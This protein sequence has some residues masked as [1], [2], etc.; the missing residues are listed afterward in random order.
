M[1]ES[2]SQD[3]PENFLPF[4][5]GTVISLCA[6]E[7]P[8]GERELF[9]EFA[10]LLSALVH[11]GYHVRGSAVL[12]AYQV[13]DPAEDVRVLGVATTDDRAAARAT[14]ERELIAL[15]EAADFTR[16]AADEIE[17][18]FSE[19]ALMKVRL[20]VDDTD[21]EKVLFFRRGIAQRSETVRSLFGLRRRRIEFTSYSMVLVYVAFAESS[22]EPTASTVMVKL[23]QNV[24]RNDL[25]ML[26]PSVRV[27]MRPVDKL[28][29]GVPAVVS[30]IIV[31][32]TK[33]VGSLGL[34][35]LLAAF[36]LGLREESV[37]LDRTAL[38]TLG[39][40]AAAFG[41]YVVR[42][43]TKFKNRRIELM[44]TLS[45]HLYFRNLDN[46]S[47]V[48]GRLLAAAEDSEVKETVLAYHFL[49]TA[50]TPLT[51]LELDRRVENWFRDRW[52]TSFDF[53]V[54]DGLRTLRALGLLIEDADGT[55]RVLELGE[56]R[57]RVDRHWDDQFSVRVSVS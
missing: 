5:P 20:E 4:R 44:K 42:Q 6:R 56:A 53:A 17:R 10:H 11:Y 35:V 52:E 22:R 40:G 50:P 28:L 41:G 43:L 33:L 57:V 49:R 21:I 13:V 48:F 45:D 19:H 25:E 8:E 31:L 32:V 38:I 12:D 1:I 54:A 23:F 9:R 14:V 18:A 29:I 15:A 55:L 26:Y 30:G 36:W 51:G 7:L 3:E 47:G 2:P 27:R 46:D 34:L 39:V 37:Q 24:P 16:I